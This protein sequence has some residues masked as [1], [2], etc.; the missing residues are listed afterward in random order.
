MICERVS[1]SWWATFKV[2]QNIFYGFEAHAQSIWGRVR[3]GGCSALWIRSIR[4]LEKKVRNENQV[5]TILTKSQPKQSFL[6]L[7]HQILQNGPNSKWSINANFD[8]KMIV[9]GAKHI[10]GNLTFCFWTFQSVWGIS[11]KSTQRPVNPWKWWK[12]QKNST[13]YWYP[14]FFTT[15]GG[16]KN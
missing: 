8:A 1:S 4:C 3:S 16:G 2:L 6:R 15:H 11:T 9:E 5:H 13:F 10:S 7:Y 12:I 14:Q